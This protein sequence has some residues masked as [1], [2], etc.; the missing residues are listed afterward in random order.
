MEIKKN[1]FEKGIRIVFNIIGEK[2]EFYTFKQLKTMYN[3]KGTF[4]DY[5]YI[6]NN[7][8]QSWITQINDDP[9]FYL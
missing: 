4:L 2:G 7:I 6:L 9:Y 5:Q 1:W 3:F 8:P